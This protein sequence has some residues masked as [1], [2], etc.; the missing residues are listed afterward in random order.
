MIFQQRCTVAAPREALWELIMDVP[1][2]AGC[3]PGVVGVER[4]ED[5]AYRGVMNV[6]VGPIRLSLAGSVVIQRQDRERWQAAMVSEATDRKLGGGLKAV[7]ELSL[8]GEDPEQT[9]LAITTN[10]TFLGKL[11]EFGQPIIRKK[12]D[13]ILQEFAR[14]LQA[15]LSGG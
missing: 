15:R 13:A 4:V 11:G 12:A 7:M 3:I 6:S 8:E 14:N 10:A 1:Q 2:V 5:N 9:E